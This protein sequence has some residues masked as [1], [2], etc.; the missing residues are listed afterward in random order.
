MVAIRYHYMTSP[1]RRQTLPQQLANFLRQKLI[2]DMQPGEALPSIHQLAVKYQVSPMTLRSAL[3]LLDQQG[4]I[5]VRHGSGTYVAE[6][7]KGRHIALVFKFDFA[8]A[9][10]MSPYWMRL[11]QFLR[12]K[13]AAQNVS[14]R[15]Y[16]GLPTEEAGRE[17]RHC[18]EL[19]EDFLLDRLTGI[20]CPSW[21]LEKE[22][23]ES[24]SRRNIPVLGPSRAYPHSVAFDYERFVVEAVARTL[25]SGRR[26]IAFIE[27]DPYPYP[28]D[29]S[30][31]AIFKREMV[32]R[33]ISVNDS[34]LRHDI[35]PVDSAG[36]S[37][38]REIWTSSREKPD[39]VIVTDDILLKGVLRAAAE[40][41]ITANSSVSIVSQAI[42][43]MDYDT[44]L[45][46]DL[47]EVDA[48]LAAEHMVNHIVSLTRGVEFTPAHETI[49]M[50][51]RDDSVLVDDS[52]L[53][54]ASK[55][56]A[57][58]RLG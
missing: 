54:D 41:Q 20:V 33:G 44:P 13:L 22:F 28:R 49:P 3:S 58:S 15:L 4:V 45:P 51:W 1:F 57:G 2:A 5:E 34:W 21:G 42:K 8:K 9:D 52:V 11:A 48:E 19:G 50:L 6:P 16:L 39:A 18:P 56:T 53:A 40:M 27:W 38:F 55:K 14:S 26:K 24:A 46:L 47:C 36:W 29:E 43:G 10:T 12:L 35:K 37:Q 32:S 23:V 7:R 30:L 17:V 31:R 25:K